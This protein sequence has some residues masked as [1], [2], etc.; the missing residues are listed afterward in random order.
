[1][2]FINIIVIIII[3]TLKSNLYGGIRYSHH[4]FSGSSWSGYEICVVCHTPHNANQ[5]VFNSALWNHQNTA[6]S[7]QTYTSSTLNAT[8]GQ[9]SGVSKLCLACHD[10][11]IAIDSYGGTSNGTRFMTTG[12]FGTDMRN[13]H[14]ISFEYST[15]LANADGR[16][17]DPSTQSSGL[18][19]TIAQDL[20]VNNKL[21]CIS[22]H[23]VHVHRNTSG[24][25][26]CH[27]MHP[28]QTITLSLRKSNS[29]SALCLTCHN[30]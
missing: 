12:S 10:G 19:N 18:G 14:P 28:F 9:P 21:E 5:T 23:D 3:I 26:G 6:S 20:L 24:C 16:L 17:H 1:M 25:I 13:Q 27:Q 4:D 15:A 29:G 22:C 7:Y 2:R 11:T 30:K 8:V